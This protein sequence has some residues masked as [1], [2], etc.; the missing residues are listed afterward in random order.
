MRRNEK[1]FEQR[2]TA[3]IINS[4]FWGESRKK[5]CSEEVAHKAH[6]LDKMPAVCLRCN[7]CIDAAT[8]SICRS[9][10]NLTTG[11]GM[12]FLKEGE[13]TDAVA[14]RHMLS[15]QRLFEENGFDIHN[16]HR[17]GKTDNADAGRNNRELQEGLYLTMP[18]IRTGLT[19]KMVPNRLLKT[20][21]YDIV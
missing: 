16:T 10:T 20:G 14:R 1:R 21:R 5:F 6:M 3:T 7:S 11:A 2:N 13:C 17:H 15:K 19:A 4:K 12:G 18:E 8:A 9:F